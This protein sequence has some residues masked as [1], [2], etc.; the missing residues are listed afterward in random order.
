MRLT[1]EWNRGGCVD[2]G[3]VMLA[4]IGGGDAYADLLMLSAEEVRAGG[5]VEGM[6]W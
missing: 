2:G 6:T 3:G 4:D 5:G 1:G